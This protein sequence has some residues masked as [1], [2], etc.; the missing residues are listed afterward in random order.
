MLTRQGH[1]CRNDKR[2]PDERDGQFDQNETD[3][4][5]NPAE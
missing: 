2:L 3:N 4:E 1:V 5:R